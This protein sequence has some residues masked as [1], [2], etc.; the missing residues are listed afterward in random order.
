MRPMRRE[1]TIA[2]AGSPRRA[3]SV[4]DISTPIMVPEVTSRRRTGRLGSAEPMIQYQ[5]AARKKRDSAIRAQ[6]SSTQPISD[7]TMLAT[8]LSTPILFA[9][10]AVS[11]MPSAPAAPRLSRRAMRRRRTPP[12]GGLGSSEG[13]RCA[14]LRGPP[15][16]GTSPA[17]RATSSLVVAGAGASAARS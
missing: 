6:E 2:R 14:R 1:M 4:A 13:R 12:S 5:D 8:T 7:L 11:P 10:S 3:G 16:A 15:L 17:R 9:A